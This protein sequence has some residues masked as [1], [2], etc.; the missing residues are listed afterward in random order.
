MKCL[1]QR[2]SSASV[3]IAGQEYSRIGRGSLLLLGIDNSDSDKQVLVAAEKI[4]NYRLFA[5]ADGKMNLSLKESG[6][7]LLIVPQF[8]LS[9]STRKGLRPSFSS[10]AS[11]Q[12]AIPLYRQFIDQCRN[13]VPVATGEFGADMQVHLVNDGPVT[14]YFDIP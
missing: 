12:Q 4:L 11:P 1:L 6:G 13:Q 10:A 7:S 5:D 9:A 3:T 2:V 8:T 14:F